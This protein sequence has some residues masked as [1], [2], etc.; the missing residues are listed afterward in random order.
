MNLAALVFS[1]TAVTAPPSA[2]NIPPPAPSATSPVRDQA[3]AGSVFAELMAIDTSATTGA[4]TPAAQAVA[5]R[6]RAAGVAKSD[7]EILGPTA[8]KQA[9][10]ARLRGTAGDKLPP[11]LL[12]GHLDVVTARRSDWSMPPYQ[13]T[14]KDGFFYGRGSLDMKSLVALWIADLIRLAREHTHRDRDVILALTPDEED[15]SD[16]GVAWYCAAAPKSR[17]RPALVESDAWCPGARVDRT[18]LI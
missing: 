3:L 6:L 12:L 17:P 8:A 13:L 1:A 16:N 5:R 4:T 18:S 15:G 7:V 9:V 14:E 10:V 2:T 11:L